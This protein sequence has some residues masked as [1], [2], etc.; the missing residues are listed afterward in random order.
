MLTFEAKCFILMK[1]AAVRFF[2]TQL[3]VCGC[4]TEEAC[5]RGR[6]DS[7]VQHV[8]KGMADEIRTDR[9]LPCDNATR[10]AGDIIE[11]STDS[12]P[13]FGIKRNRVQLPVLHQVPSYFF[14]GGGGGGLVVIQVG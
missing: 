3:A 7:L 12:G 6:Y 2:I 9:L 8:S 4:R 11:C 14:T 10:L 5:A 1:L 13:G